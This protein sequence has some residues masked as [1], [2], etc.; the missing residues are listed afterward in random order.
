[1]EL[2]FSRNGL[3]VWSFGSVYCCNAVV[4]RI[5]HRQLLIGSTLVSLLQK[6]VN[7]LV[8]LTVQMDQIFWIWTERG[9][10]GN[11]DEVWGGIYTNSVATFSICFWTISLLFTLYA[12]ISLGWCY[13]SIFILGWSTSCRYLN[14]DC[15]KSI[16][17]K[18]SNASDIII[19]HLGCDEWWESQPRCMRI[20][21]NIWVRMVAHNEMKIQPGTLTVIFF[22]SIL[23]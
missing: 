22:E 12:M 9:I 13:S 11:C 6:C 10:F 14:H 20:I 3:C 17:Q 8:L 18:R 2:N 1:M 16:F 7:L 23:R 21:C 4:E 15:T 5:L 19:L